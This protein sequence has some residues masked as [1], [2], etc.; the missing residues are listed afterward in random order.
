MLIILFKIFNE[1]TFK[2]I[3]SN[4]GFDSCIENMKLDAHRV[5]CHSYLV[6]QKSF[7]GIS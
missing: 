2:S 3:P 5:T 6:Q 1:F 4:T 7:S